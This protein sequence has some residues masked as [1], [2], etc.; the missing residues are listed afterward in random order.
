MKSLRYSIAV[1]FLLLLTA[2]GEDKKTVAT[3]LPLSLQRV[4]QLTANDGANDGVNGGADHHDE[5]DNAEKN[6][7]DRAPL[8]PRQTCGLPHFRTALLARVNQARDLTRLCGGVIYR[9][10]EP[11]TWNMALFRAAA[12]HA[13]EMAAHNY[14]LHTSRDGS[15]TGERITG[16]GYAWGTYAENIAAGQTTVDQVMRDWL[17]SPG[18]CVNIMRHRV[19]E[20]GVACVRN[21][22]SKYKWYWSM[23]F[24]RPAASA[25]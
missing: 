3:N 10:V 25:H 12:G 13:A 16:A 21:D 8:P 6:A 1:L 2:C 22:A 19:T 23:E 4:A 24:A 9:A 14:F 18:H 5:V 17:A 15:N 7:F 20:M 11:V